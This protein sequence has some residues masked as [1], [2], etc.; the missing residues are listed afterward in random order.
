MA[1]Y[2]PSWLRSWLSRLNWDIFTWHVYLGDAIES[3]IDWVI[4]GLNNLLTL[5]QDAWNRATVLW[6][7]F[8]AEARRLWSKLDPV[9]EW[10]RGLPGNIWIEVNSWWNNPDNPIR[11]FISATVANVGVAINNVSIFLGNLQVTWDNFRTAILPTLLNWSWWKGWWGHTF[12]SF[13]EWEGWWWNKTQDRID[14][15]VD[16]VRKEVNKQAS[17]LELIKDFIS[18]PQKFLYEVFDKIIERFW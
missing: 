15:E 1:I 17:W 12:S 4:D 13:T 2:K 14:A 11:N 7:D 5:A 6:S 10:F 9:W 8:W 3:G 16:P 18:D